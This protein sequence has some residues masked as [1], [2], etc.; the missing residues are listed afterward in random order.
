MKTN[1]TLKMIAAV[2]VATLLSATNPLKTNAQTAGI[3]NIVIVHGA[4]ADAS[5]WEAVYKILVKDG[6]KVT[7][8]QNQ[9]RV[10]ASGRPRCACGPFLGRHSNYAGRYCR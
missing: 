8:V 1:S 6:Y 4:F 2:A 9:F 10:R 7:L 3:K 5:G